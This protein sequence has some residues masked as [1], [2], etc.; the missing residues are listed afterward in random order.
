MT[1]PFIHLFKIDQ[2]LHWSN[3]WQKYFKAQQPF[4]R[5]FIQP[6]PDFQGPRV[7][8]HRF[9]FYGWTLSSKF[10]IYFERLHSTQITIFSLIDDRLLTMYCQYSDRHRSMSFNKIKYFHRSTRSS[11][12]VFSILWSRSSDGIQLKSNIFMNQRVDSQYGFSRFTMYR[13]SNEIVHFQ[14]LNSQRGN[15]SFW[16]AT[17]HELTSKVHHSQSMSLS[18]LIFDFTSKHLLFIMLYGDQR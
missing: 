13:P 14:F 10:S 11:N 12:Y 3:F 8:F 9:H 2:L 4:I 5:L 7:R 1:E 6:Q 16:M 15:E 18:S 17:D